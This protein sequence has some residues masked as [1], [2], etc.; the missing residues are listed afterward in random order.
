M[1]ERYCVPTS[2]PW[3]FSVVGSWTAKKISSTSRRLMRWL[4]NSTRTT[5]LWPVSPPHTCW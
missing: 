4:S 1:P 3:R 5:S 2:A